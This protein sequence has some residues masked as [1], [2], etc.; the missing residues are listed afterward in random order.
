MVVIRRA[1]GE[2]VGLDCV[3]HMGYSEDL[4]SQL[5]INAGKLQRV[6]CR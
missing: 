5:W 2:L 4:G 1:C 3:R 6:L